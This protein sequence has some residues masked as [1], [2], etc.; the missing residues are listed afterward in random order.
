MEGGVEAV[1]LGDDLAGHVVTIEGVE[2]G[3]GGGGALVDVELLL[4]GDSAVGSD[5]SDRD[6]GG[7]AGVLTGD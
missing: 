6:L 3:S 2:E 4:S 7:Q 5:E 1:G